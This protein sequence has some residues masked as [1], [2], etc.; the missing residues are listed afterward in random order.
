MT[1]IGV[2]TILVLLV[3]F[4]GATLPSAV[5]PSSLADMFFA[6]NTPGISVDGFFREASYGQVSATGMVAGP[7]TLAGWY[8]GCNVGAMLND[9]VNAA[10][11][12]GV[13]VNNYAR[14]VLVY[15]D[16]WGCGWGGYTAGVGSGTTSIISGG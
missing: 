7:Y 16:I 15:P 3:T 6:A 2:Q 12:A 14:V 9:A 8:S 11:A 10:T 5:T 4:P 13:N 1:L